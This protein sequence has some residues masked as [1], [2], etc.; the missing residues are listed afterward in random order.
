M[1]RFVDTTLLNMIEDSRQAAIKIDSEFETEYMDMPLDT[2]AF[3]LKRL[4][5][6]KDCKII[7]DPNEDGGKSKA[8]N[9]KTYIDDDSSTFVIFVADSEAISIILAFG[10]LANEGYFNEQS[11]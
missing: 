4:A 5:F 10:W 7:S 6:K 1:P 9:V 11:I 8:Y 2:L 3:R